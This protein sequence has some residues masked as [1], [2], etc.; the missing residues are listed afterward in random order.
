MIK[1]NKIQIY[2][3]PVW[4]GGACCTLLPITLHPSA[5][6]HLQNILS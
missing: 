4:E 1:P 5:T 3:A 6:E 2:W